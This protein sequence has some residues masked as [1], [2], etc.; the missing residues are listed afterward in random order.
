ML[1]TTCVQKIFCFH[2]INPD[3]SLIHEFNSL[4]HLPCGAPIFHTQTHPHATGMTFYQLHPHVTIHERLD[5][6]L[7]LGTN[8]KSAVIVRGLSREALRNFNGQHELAHIA[9]QSECSIADLEALIQQLQAGGFIYETSSHEAIR[10]LPHQDRKSLLRESPVSDMAARIETVIYVHGL[11]RLGV[12][13]GSL[14]RESG[15]PHIRFVDDRLVTANDVQTWG[16]SR[17]DIGERRDRTLALIHEAALAGALHKQIHPGVSV[18]GELHI[19]V[20]D[21]Q[22]DWAVFNP[23]LAD[24]FISEGID[25]LMIAYADSGSFISPVISK[26]TTGCLRCHFHMIADRDSSWPGIFDNVIHQDVSDRAP[27]GLLV[28]TAIE[29][30]A[31]LA[32]HL[33]GNEDETLLEILW[34]TRELLRVDWLAHP[35]CGCQWDRMD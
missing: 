33:G 17:V 4:T 35:G 16:F 15:F 11:N 29:T 22:S 27:I 34:P 28:D 2:K 8:P 20:C 9:T 12:L 21:Q 10:L 13:I 24:T 30:V 25:H 32:A 5:G 14:L 19:I 31:R 1:S 6:D 18:P 3:I 26:S 7:Q 23:K